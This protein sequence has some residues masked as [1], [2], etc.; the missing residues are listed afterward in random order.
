MWSI[1]PVTP[2]QIP[3]LL[4]LIHELAQFER[5]EHEVGATVASLN[6]S[7]FG[8]QPAAAALLAH[9]DGQPVGYAIYY[10][11]FSSFVGRRG[12]WLDDVYVRPE[13]RRQGIGLALIKAVAR[14]GV[15][16][17][18]GR[19]EWTALDW[20]ENALNFYRRL[21]ARTLDDWVL[22]RTDAAGLRRIAEI[23]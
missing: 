9:S 3:G 8:P 5:L 10:W 1:Q 16:R 22:L 15:E 20:N 14:N 2:E 7:F 12:I 19:F 17:G 13:F 11:T 23:T 6:E 4:E 21:G 18:C